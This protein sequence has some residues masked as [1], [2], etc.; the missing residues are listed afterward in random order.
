MPLVP[1]ALLVVLCLCANGL[2]TGSRKFAD[3]TRIHE[4]KRP[5]EALL[6]WH[7][8]D[9]K[10]RTVL[11]FDNELAIY[12]L[13]QGSLLNRM[14]MLDKKKSLPGPANFVSLAA[15]DGIMRRAF[16]VVPDE[17]WPD[18]EKEAAYFPFVSRHNSAVRFTIEGTPIVI[19]TLGNLPEISEKVLLYVNDEMLP[20]RHRA[21]VQN[22]IG[23]RRAD[24]VLVKRR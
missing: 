4:I 7:K 12:P 10:G 8:A 9:V 19:T 21:Y 11:F 15:Y 3:G 17:S 16:I 6:L 18:R 13:L 14:E 1:V 24:V 5:E 22:L 23:A 20:D 2:G